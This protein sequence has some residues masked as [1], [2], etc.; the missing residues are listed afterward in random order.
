MPKRKSGLFIVV[1]QRTCQCARFSAGWSWTLYAN[2][3]KHLAR[4]E[5]SWNSAATARNQAYKFAKI[6]GLKI[7]VRTAG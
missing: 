2:G 5:Y 1:A 3:P 6:L 4:S 7:P